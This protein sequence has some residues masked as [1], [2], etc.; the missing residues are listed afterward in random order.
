VK[1]I[2]FAEIKERWTRK[3]ILNFQDVTS[4]EFYTKFKMDVYKFNVLHLD[5]SIKIKTFMARSIDEAEN[6][7]TELLK[8]YVTNALEPKVEMEY[9][10]VYIFKNDLQ[11]SFKLIIGGVFHFFVKVYQD[12]LE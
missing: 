1:L 5:A 8:A 11:R 12:G 10:K 4:Y 6:H 9:G 7:V 3:N 2:L